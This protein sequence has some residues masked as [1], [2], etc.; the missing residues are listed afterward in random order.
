MAGV[1]V[2]A[3]V[4]LDLVTGDELRAELAELQRALARRR[5]HMRPL[6][7]TATAGSSGAVLVL[8]RCSR[9]YSW[10]LRSL[11]VV[12]GA[13]AGLITVAVNIAADP[14]AVDAFTQM[15]MEPCQGLTGLGPLYVQRWK[16]QLHIAGGQALVVAVGGAG[17]SAGSVFTATAYVGELENS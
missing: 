14:S 3:G 12:G 9:A 17:A 10:D 1:Q 16:D 8:G 2:A 7:A 5:V 4:E 15:W 6:S 11:A 13:V